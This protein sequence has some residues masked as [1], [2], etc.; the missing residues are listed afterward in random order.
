TLLSLCD[1]GDAILVPVPSYPLFD[2]LA[3]LCGVRLIRYPLRYDG[4]FHVDLGS[5]PDATLAQREKVKA[6]FC[7]S[8]NNPT[9]NRV[10]SEEL[11]RFLTLGVPLVFDEVFLPYDRRGAGTDPLLLGD[12]SPLVVVLDGLSKRA[13]APGLKSGWLLA[14]GKQ[15]EDF[16]KRIDWVS[17]AY[18]SC[19]SVAAHVLPQILAREHEVQACI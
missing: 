11:E 18:L 8:P 10:S 17:D 16:L 13:G 19:S 9:G 15:R 6:I 2:Q 4:S 12:R 14:T 5:F 3:Q 7:V 1:P